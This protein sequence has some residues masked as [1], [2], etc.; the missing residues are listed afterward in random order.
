LPAFCCTIVGRLGP[1]TNPGIREG[2]VCSVPT[3]YGPV[4]GMACY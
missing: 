4:G 1:F 2:E 3:A